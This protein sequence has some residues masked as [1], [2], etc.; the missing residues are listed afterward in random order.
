MKLRKSVP[1]R[2]VPKML[3]RSLTRRRPPVLYPLVGRARQIWFS[4]ADG[5]ISWGRMGNVIE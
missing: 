1:L 5:T 3:H 2:R 4:Y